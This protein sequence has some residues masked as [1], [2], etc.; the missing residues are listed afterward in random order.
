MIRKVYEGDPLLGPKYSGQMKIIAFINDHS[1]V[2]KIV[3]HLKLSFKATR[4]SPP[5]AQI[6][7]STA[8]EERDEYL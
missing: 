2:D 1:V 5:Q 4:S 6:L 8:T 7:L 3:N